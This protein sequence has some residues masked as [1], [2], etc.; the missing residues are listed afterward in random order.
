MAHY[1]NIEDE[2]LKDLERN[3]MD[4]KVQFFETE[5]GFIPI[6][7]L[8]DMKENYGSLAP[9]YGAEKVDVDREWVGIRLGKQNMEI[10]EE[11]ENEESEYLKALD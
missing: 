11:E 3:Q 5:K 6:V 8:W 4:T 2:M 7:A 9:F 1:W 10:I